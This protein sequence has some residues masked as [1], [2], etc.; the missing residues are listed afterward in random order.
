MVIRAA[1]CI[2]LFAM[3][4]PAQW[5]RYADLVGGV[6]DSP[7]AHGL[8]YFKVDP[9][10]RSDKE[11]R[12]ADCEE[13]PSKAEVQ[14]R[15]GTRTNL[16]VAG[17]IGD[18]TIYDLEYFR[19]LDYPGP[20]LRSVL[21]ETPSHQFHEILVQERTVPGTLFPTKIVK[22]GQE[23]VIGAKCD[24]GGM[25]HSVDEHYFVMLDGVA[26]LLDFDTVIHAAEAILPRGVFTYQ[27]M[28]I[29]DFTSLM[30]SIGTEG[31]GPIISAKMGCCSGRVTVPFRVEKGIVLAGKAVFDPDWNPFGAKRR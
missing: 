11:D 13:P 27:P 12:I 14:R 2:I 5:K 16:R 23:P 4:C 30:Y 24:D 18:F 15:A 7:P 17:K 29:F 20:H 10:S 8:Q 3:A 22:A 9:C 19:G 28:T 6:N 21:V 26:V 1:L 31:P 25:Y